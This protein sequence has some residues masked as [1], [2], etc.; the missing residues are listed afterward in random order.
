MLW[1]ILIAAGLGVWALTK[2][3]ALAI[4]V[5]LPFVPPL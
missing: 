3:V 2:N 4:L 1:A 5:A